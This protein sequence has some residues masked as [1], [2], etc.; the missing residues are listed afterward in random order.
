MS[1]LTISSVRLLSSVEQ[2]LYQYSVHNAKHPYI[3]T[4]FELCRTTVRNVKPTFEPP[5]QQFKTCGLSKP[6]SWQ[7]E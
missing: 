2:K 1:L 3:T 7:S 4:V 5:S 6:T